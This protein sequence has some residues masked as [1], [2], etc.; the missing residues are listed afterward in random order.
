MDNNI[1]IYILIMAAVSFLIRSLPVTL[2]KKP[3]KN[4]FIQSFLYYVPYVTLAVMTFPAIIKATQSIYSGIA[5]F[6]VGLFVAW[7]GFD[8]FKVA[9][10][11]CLIVLI[12]E[13]FLI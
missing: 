6:I 9:S 12:L 10:S 7:K 2:I 4:Q 13:F 8:L 1:Y 5:A 3:I 11:C